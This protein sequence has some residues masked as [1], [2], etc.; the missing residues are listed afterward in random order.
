MLI[1]ENVFPKTYAIRTAVSAKLS[2]T[3]GLL[4]N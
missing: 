2:G 1:P 4:L 3:K